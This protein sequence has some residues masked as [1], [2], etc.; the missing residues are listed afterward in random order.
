MREIIESMLKLSPYPVAYKIDNWIIYSG[1]LFKYPLN[2]KLIELDHFESFSNGWNLD[3]NG[4]SVYKT[5][6]NISETSLSFPLVYFGLRINSLSKFHGKTDNQSIVLDELDFLNQVNSTTE[7]LNK[8]LTST[9][10]S[11][12]D[13]FHDIRALNGDIYQ[14]L[15]KMG[16]LI[17]NYRIDNYELSEQWKSLES[18]NE[19]MSSRLDYGEYLFSQKQPR[20]KEIAV[21]K[22]IDSLKRSLSPN[23][24]MLGNIK[25]FMNGESISIIKAPS[26]LSIIP[27]ILIDN[28]IK[29]SPPDK[30]INITVTE[31]S[32]EIRVSVDSIGPRVEPNE[33]TNIFLSGV[34]GK[35][36]ENL[37]EGSGKGLCIANDLLD[38]FF[39]T[40]LIFKQDYSISEIYKDIRHHPTKFSFALHK[41]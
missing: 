22:T 13:T 36:A 34:R 21:Y 33:Q 8:I 32:D 38:T 20:I 37:V 19:F 15:Y 35:N 25:I 24:K 2:K 5:R 17:N 10:T 18:L 4:F 23:A 11:I 41:N 14:G 31:T 27:H 28:A 7:I 16:G 6:L 12:T 30:S 9:I 1:K 29:Y 39:H 26:F 40:K 3:R